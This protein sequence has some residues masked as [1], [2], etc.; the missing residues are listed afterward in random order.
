MINNYE[1]FK[2]QVFSITSIDLNAYKEK[3]MK[4]RIDTLIARNKYDGY[5]SYIKVIKSDSKLLDEFVNYLTINVSEFYRNPALWKKLEDIILPELINK[6]GTRLKIWSAAC[7]T[8]DEPYSL[9]MVLAKKVP[10][11]DIKIYAT[12]IDDQVLE[13]A[14]DGVYSAN[15][16]KGLPDEYKNKYFE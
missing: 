16:L 4:R 15:S 12:D 10:M 14:K 3:Q 13:K 8:G 6:F 9:A 7:S 11:R 5:E 1:D 2:K